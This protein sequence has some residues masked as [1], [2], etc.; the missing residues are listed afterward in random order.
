MGTIEP[1]PASDSVKPYASAAQAV[2]GGGPTSRVE[3]AGGV[4]PTPA[5]RFS[6]ADDPRVVDALRQMNIALEST[7]ACHTALSMAVGL[8]NRVEVKFGR[9]P[10]TPAEIDTTISALLVLKHAIEAGLTP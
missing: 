3:I 1:V 9:W 5:Q 6:P 10:A 2:D 8:T 4:T 7:F